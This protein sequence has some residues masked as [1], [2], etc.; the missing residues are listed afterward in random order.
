MC[1]KI[2]SLLKPSNCSIIYKNTLLI[3]TRNNSK[4]HIV[5]L[6]YENSN[7]IIDHSAGK[8]IWDIKKRVNSLEILEKFCEA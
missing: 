8:C 6:D 5:A 7:I 2:I 1:V 3:T 4:F